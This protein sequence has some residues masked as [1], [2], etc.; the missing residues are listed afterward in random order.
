MRF[1][2]SFGAHTPI[3]GPTTAAH[4]PAVCCLAWNRTQAP[5]TPP[6][7]TPGSGENPALSATSHTTTLP[8]Q[9]R[10]KGLVSMATDQEV[11]ELVT[12]IQGRK[13]RKCSSGSSIGMPSLTLLKTCGLFLSFSG[14]T[15]LTPA[16][17]PSCELRQPGNRISSAGSQSG[18]G[19]AAEK[20]EVGT[21]FQGHFLIQFF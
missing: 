20:R 6:S 21:G 10:Q 2:S 3:R 18:C 9:S 4:C 16:P 19:E 15:L 8:T 7:P 17:S 5:S 11:A 1:I 12:R 14:S 13:P